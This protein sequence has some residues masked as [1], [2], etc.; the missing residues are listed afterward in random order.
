MEVQSTRLVRT[1]SW[2]GDG[3]QFIFNSASYS[4]GGIYATDYSNVSW[5][6]D[7]TQFTSN[8]ADSDGGAMHVSYDS[9][10]YWDGDCAQ[11]TSNSA[12]QHGSAIYATDNASVSWDG[13]DTQFTSNSAL[14]WQG[15]GGGA[16]YA[17]DATVSWVGDG[18]QFT[19][20]YADDDSRGG[21]GGAIYAQLST[22]SWSGN[23]TQ[24][25]SNSAVCSR[26]RCNLR[27]FC[28]R[29]L[30]W[31]HE[32][33]RQLRGGI[34]R[35]PSLDR[36][37]WRSR[38]CRRGVLEQYRNVRWGGVHVQLWGPYHLHRRNVSFELG[39]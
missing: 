5:D 38:V 17:I 6:T 3:A 14:A 10:V 36:I 30:G 7:G 15:Y 33:Q 16:I 39:Q 20:N 21:Y 29:G 34:R 2:Y 35:R 9:A 32:L 24:F 23:N 31:K 19:S 18:T 13:D 11:F 22:L 1:G 4:G 12:D 8:S 28:E 25:S 37:R 27:D 26:W